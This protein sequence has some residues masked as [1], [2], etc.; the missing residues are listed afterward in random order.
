LDAELQAAID[1]EAAEVR[2]AISDEAARFADEVGPI[3]LTLDEALGKL[4]E[5]Y[6][7]LKRKMHAADQRGY[8][9]GAAVVQSALTQTLRAAL[10]RIVEL[11]IELPHAG[12]CRSFSSL[13]QAWAGA[14]RGAAARILWPPTPAAPSPSPR[15][16]GSN[17]AKPVVQSEPPDRS[18]P[19]QVDVSAPLPGDDPTF[20]AYSDPNE[21]N[22]ALVAASRGPK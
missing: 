20:V 11:S 6:L 9:P 5:G 17:G 4:R 1:R 14:A 13:T 16:N 3:G 21:A 19:N 8:G 2:K 10:W 22:A 15:P 7:E 18:I 12:L